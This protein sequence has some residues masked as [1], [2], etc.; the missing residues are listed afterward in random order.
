MNDGTQEEELYVAEGTW[1]GGVSPATIKGEIKLVVYQTNQEGEIMIL[2][3]GFDYKV[4]WIALP[5]NHKD[6]IPVANAGIPNPMDPE[7]KVFVNDIVEFHGNYSYDPN[8]DLNSNGSIEPELGEVD[9]LRYKWDFGDGI[10]TTFSAMNKKITHIYSRDTIPA[11]LEYKKFDVHLWA[12]D[13]EG[14]VDDDWTQVMVFRGN[15]TPK[16][17]SLKINEVEY[18]TRTRPEIQKVPFYQKIHFQALAIDLDDDELIYQWDLDGDGIYDKIGSAEIATNFEYTYYPG[19]VEIGGILITLEVTDGTWETENDTFTV[20]IEVCQNIKPVPVIFAQKEGD[21]S[22]YYNSITVRE[23]QKITFFGSDS[24]D[25]DNLPKEYGA[26]PWN[27]P[28]TQIQ[29][30]W[31]FDYA[32]DQSLT[33]GWSFSSEFEYVYSSSNTD[34]MYTVV[35]EV[36]DGLDTNRSDEFIVVINFPPVPVA[37]IKDGSYSETGQLY[38]DT[39]VYFDG[40]DSYDP[41][42]D[43][44]NFT[45]DFGDQCPMTFGVDPVHYYKTPGVYTVKLLV[46]DGDHISSPFKLIVTIKE[47]PLPP[48]AIIKLSTFQTLTYTD[49]WFDASGSYDPDGYYYDPTDPTSFAK[50]IVKYYWDFGDGNHSNEINI[51]H[52]YARDGVYTITLTIRD[53][54]GI[55]STNTE[56]TLEVKNRI[57]IA[58]PG[59]DRIVNAG[60]SILFSGAGSWDPD[61]VVVKYLWNLGDGTEPLWNDDTNTKHTYTEPGKYYVTL[62]VVDDNGDVS[63]GASITVTVQSDDSESGYEDILPLLALAALIIIITVIITALI[64]IRT[65]QQI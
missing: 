44:I 54:A 17:S 56:Y 30:K 40:S 22:A 9:N 62:Q 15:H 36:S 26:D 35:L 34:L 64:Y 32:N 12:Q 37:R 19:Y 55:S 25:P 46:S 60:E 51:T 45:W 28:E 47:E 16:I 52:A 58:D 8:D 7:K 21:D 29:Y 27:D 20:I 5:Y 10:Q 3:C 6:L 43:E 24:Y 38:S 2:Y 39:A 13:P 65:R 18:H 41:N 57:P 4:S 33:S 11:G 63:E 48:T 31:C 42:G 1:Q 23:D 53:K 61:G 49:V 14:H 50:D 59:P